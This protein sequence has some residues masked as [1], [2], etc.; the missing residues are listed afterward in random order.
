[1]IIIISQFLGLKKFIKN[2][3]KKSNTNGYELI[4][5]ECF[6]KKDN[7]DDSISNDNLLTSIRHILRDDGIFAFNLRP[8]SF[9]VYNDILES[10]KKKYKKVIEINFRICSGLLICSRNE[11]I[12]LDDYYKS[13]ILLDEYFKQDILDKLS[14]NSEDSKTEEE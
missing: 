11:K 6:S 3:K 9:K 13:I 14:I 5:L 10:L 4:L 7:S 2:W 12:N 8:E 1:M